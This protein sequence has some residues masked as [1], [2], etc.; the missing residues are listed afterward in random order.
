[1]ML[2]ISRLGAGRDSGPEGFTTSG[3]FFAS[4][5]SFFGFGSGR[6]EGGAGAIEDDS[7]N[8]ETSKDRG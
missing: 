3:S 1:M 6:G 4:G 2:P 5:V 7:F 8:Q